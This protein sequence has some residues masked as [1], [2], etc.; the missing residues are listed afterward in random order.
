MSSFRQLT[1]GSMNDQR[2]LTDALKKLGYNP[3]VAENQTVRG[4]TRYDNRDG[5]QIV[6][7]KEDTALR[8]D[9]GFKKQ[10]DGFYAIG[11]DS[12]IIREFTPETFVKKV[13]GEYT[14]MKAQST[15]RKLGLRV[16]GR[17]EIE[18]NG[19]QLTRLQYEKVG[20]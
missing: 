15:A 16:V 13:Q 18:V 7:R 8:G 4:D 10:A 3:I 9:I 14:V 2:C 19:R 17:K 1:A 12:Y 11:M 5:Y 20:A 6:L